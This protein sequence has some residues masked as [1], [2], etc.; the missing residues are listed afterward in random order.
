MSAGYTQKGGNCVVTVATH[1]GESYLCIVL[2]GLDT[3][4]VNYGYTVANRLID[5]AYKNYANMEV[6]S[7]KT[8]ICTVPVT[9]SDLVT[10]VEIRAKDSV[11]AYLPLGLEIGKDIQYSIRLTHTTLEAP[12]TEGTFVGYVA[13]IYNGT[14][15]TTAPLYTAGSAERSGFIG[16][17]KNIEEWTSNRAVLAG[18][19][20]FV[21]ALIAWI[22]TENVIRSRRRKKWDKYFSDKMVLPPNPT[23]KQNRKR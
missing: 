1:N 20:F 22:V 4:K 16:R 7:P 13:V 15:L 11:V 2:G 10:E 3:E 17:L 5:W 23:P 18:L 6:L 12:V 21:V 19:I 14:V 9:V 8:L